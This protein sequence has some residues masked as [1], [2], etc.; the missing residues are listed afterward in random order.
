MKATTQYVQSSA[1]GIHTP[2]HKVSASFKGQLTGCADPAGTD[3]KDY[4][5][6]PPKEDLNV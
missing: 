4:L 1:T 2:G 5:H 3:W 6:K